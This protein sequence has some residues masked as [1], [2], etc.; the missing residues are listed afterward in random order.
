[1]KNMKVD[2]NKQ[3][4]INNAC[5]EAAP[6]ALGSS[7]LDL[8]AA[9]SD[10]FAQLPHIVFTIT[11]TATILKCHEKSVRRLI[12]RNLLSASRG[13]RHIR[14]TRQAI[15]AYLANTSKK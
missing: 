12:D 10:N 3:T 2:A 8:S 15:L 11:E 13:L 14:V 5:S 9:S 4:G 6:A 7:A 1:M